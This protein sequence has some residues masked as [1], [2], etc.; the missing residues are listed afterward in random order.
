MKRREQISRRESIAI[1]GGAIAWPVAARA[2]QAAMPVIGFLSTRAPEE[3]A[4]LVEAFRSG[5]KDRGFVDGESVKIEFRWAHGDYGHL[6]ALAAEFVR[7]QVA[8]IATLG[9]DPSALA[10]K[11]ATSTI[12][13]VFAIGSDPVKVGLVESFNRPGGNAT[14][15]T[16]STN[17]MEP[18]RLALLRELAPGVAVVGALVNPKFP[19]AALQAKDIEE[20]ARAIGQRIVFANASADAELD[21]AFESLTSAGIGALMVTADPYLDTRRDRIIAFAARQRLPAIYQFRQFAL[22]GGVLSYGLSFTDVYRQVGRYAGMVLKGTKPADLPVEQVTKFELVI[23]MKT[24]RALGIK[25]SD[26][27][28][29]LADEVIE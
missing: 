12:P 13:I 29:S 9:G 15:I 8:V 5:L 22:A 19:A 1:V 2:Q 24:A 11:A 3:S 14:G 27:L 10:A 21:A 20:A 26:N 23:N 28:L 25:I 17:L 16:T 18:K 4:D 7:A 6:P